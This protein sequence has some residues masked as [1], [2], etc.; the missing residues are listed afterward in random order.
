MSGS[1]LSPTETESPPFPPYLALGIGVCA[2][3][4]GAIFARTAGEAPSLVIAAY[5]VGLAVLILAPFALATARREIQSL[6]ARDLRIAGLS[7]L[8][9]ALHF[10]T[11]ISSLAHTS[12]A[13]SVMLVNTT[14]LWVALFSPLIG[15]DRISGA[16]RNAI[17][18]SVAG[19]VLIGWGDVA[20]GPD[21]LWGDALALTGGICAAVYI[22]LGRNVRHRLSLA[23]YVLLCYGAAAVVLWGM[24]ITLGLPVTGFRS[25][26]VAAFWAMALIP[27]LIGHTSYNWSLKWLGAPV[28]SVSLLGEPIGSSLLAWILFRE[29]ITPHE[30]GGGILI[31]TAIVLS[32]RAQRR[33]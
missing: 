6:S 19:G 12:V 24:V 28:I 18:L 7:G 15:G 31:L 5:R 9:L 2:V 11:W 25:D 33:S 32:A 30:I 20:S 23:G 22:L 27:Q 16:A 17:L 4:T 1:S 13:C 21:A 14:P 8:F 26:T 3:S 10:A 29:S